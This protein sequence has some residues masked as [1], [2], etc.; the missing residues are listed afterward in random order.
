M[1]IRLV[2]LRN[3]SM[4]S[5]AP[6][7]L[8]L[9][10]CSSGDPIPDARGWGH[11]LDTKGI[12]R[13]TPQ[14]SPNGE[15]IVTADHRNGEF[16][17]IYLARADGSESHRLSKGENRYELDTSPSISP[18]GDRLVYATS[19]PQE[20]MR[21]SFEIETSNLDG[22]DKRTLTDSRTSSFAPTWSP[23]G[24]YIAYVHVP[25]RIGDRI[26]IADADGESEAR[27]I[28]YISDYFGP[29]Y[30]LDI[31]TPLAWSPDGRKLAFVE[32]NPRHQRSIWAL[33]LDDGLNV[34]G[35]T[36]LLDGRDYD[37][38]HT[39]VDAPSWSP[40]GQRLAF[41]Q[42]ENYDDVGYYRG[43]TLNIID[44]DGSD[45]RKVIKIEDTS[46]GYYGVVD[47]SPDGKE[48]LF[49]WSKRRGPSDGS[50][51]QEAKGTIFLV[52]MD[53]TDLREIGTGTWASWSPD[54]TRIAVANHEY[55]GFIHDL[56]T[57]APDGSD[58]QILLWGSSQEKVS[59]EEYLK[60]RDEGR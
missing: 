29:T 49:S 36:T 39:I 2:M 28:H 8:Y 5:L 54:G 57:M 25:S 23:D 34:R 1:N 32:E 51:V 26:Y 35:L 30:G 24:S 44:A 16:G 45:L 13:A 22:S 52:N 53:G 10:L 27:F 20:G 48:I 59:R 43:L 17:T 31:I 47:W 33:E 55:N 38:R 18:N 42:L 46:R 40:D 6:V 19:T 21:D 41:L 11:M 37:D 4:L 12:L 14:W 7:L 60:F 3:I 56:S 9:G 58:V 15:Y 50:T